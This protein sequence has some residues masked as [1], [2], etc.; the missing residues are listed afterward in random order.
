MQHNASPERQA[1]RAPDLNSG[2]FHTS[3][4]ANAD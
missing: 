1:D 3:R 4:A 2:P